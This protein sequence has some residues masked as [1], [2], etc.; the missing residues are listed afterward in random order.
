MARSIVPKGAH[1]GAVSQLQQQQR[2]LEAGLGS[3]HRR[4]GVKPKSV[5]H[6]VRG[7]KTIW[8]PARHSH[9]EYPYSV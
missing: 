4:P 7:R 2:A 5:G 6:F 8:C 9:D 1:P 3:L